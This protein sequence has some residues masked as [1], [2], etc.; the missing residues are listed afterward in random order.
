MIN[1]FATM[2][3]EELESYNAAKEQ[4]I[5]EHAAGYAAG[6]PID[7]SQPLYYQFGQNARMEDDD[8]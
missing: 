2:T 6:G 1:S 4:Q 8:A 7:E 5:E 3:P